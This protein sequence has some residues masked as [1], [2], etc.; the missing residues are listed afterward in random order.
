M[1]GLGSFS[2]RG[3]RVHGGRAT[4]LQPLEP[5]R[6]DVDRRRPQRRDQTVDG[7]GVERRDFRHEALRGNPVNRSR[8]GVVQILVPADPRVDPVADIQRAVG[9]D[10]D[11]RRPEQRLDRTLG[12]WRCR[13]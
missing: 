2:R 11:V 7:R 6:A 9:T 10:G 4:R 13:R 5:D 3:D 1:Y 12:A 8:Q